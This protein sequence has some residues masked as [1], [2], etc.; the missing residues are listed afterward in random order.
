MCIEAFSLLCVSISEAFGWV[1]YCTMA[2]TLLGNFVW[3]SYFHELVPLPFYLMFTVTTG[4]VEGYSGV[5]HKAANLCQRTYKSN[6][7]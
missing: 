1:E 3:V 2:V 4:D 7:V 5:S 6:T